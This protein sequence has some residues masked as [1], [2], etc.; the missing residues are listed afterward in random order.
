M[1]TDTYYRYETTG[2]LTIEGLRDALNEV[3]ELGYRVIHV[4]MAPEDPEF[5]F[6]ALLEMKGSH[7]ERQRIVQA[8]AKAVRSKQVTQ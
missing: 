4:G 8:A 2:S 1:D 7:K 5:A 3:G 6:W